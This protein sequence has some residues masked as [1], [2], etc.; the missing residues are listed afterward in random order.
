MENYKIIVGIDIGKEINLISFLHISKKEEITKRLKI[1]NNIEG[2][3]TLLEAL[4]KITKENNCK[5]E[6]VL[7]GLESTGSYWINLY[8]FF[9]R[10]NYKVVMVKNRL[11]KLKREAK[12]SQKGKNDSIDCY[13]I[14]LVLKEGDYFEIREKQV[15]FGSLQRMT[16]TKEDY[17]KV[18][19]Q[20][21]NRLRS[22]LDVNNPIYFRV[23]KSLDSILG[24]A[25]IK[26]FPSPWD[27]ININ[28]NS[29][30][31]ILKED[32]RRV[33]LRC[34]D[35]YIDLCYDLYK[36]VR[37]INEGERKEIKCYL[38]QYDI[39]EKAIN[40]LEESIECLAKET[41]PAYEK[42]I[43]I[44]GIG[45]TEIISLI[46]EIGFIENFPNA[47]ALQSFLG[48]GI[49]ADMSGSMSKESKITKAGN[50]TGRKILYHISMLLITHNDDWR[51]VYSYYKSYNRKYQNI[52]K[53]MLI[54]VACKFLRVVYGILKYNIE[55]DREELFRGY[56]F[57]KCNKEKFIKE[58]IGKSKRTISEEEIKELFG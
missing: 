29:L 1:K 44:K 14:A 12:Y 37:N 36:D 50:R 5:V 13:C 9:T 49:K 17:I 43:K 32:V 23:F 33:D 45:K 25:I 26:K 35:E 6:D 47:R 7:I 48:L 41:V 34:L 24:L 20:N 42:L 3:Y 2:F 18:K 40:D 16:R 52:N 19:V 30:I 54:A 4:N 10:R 38:D 11:V 8:H 56:D 15:G 22:W 53:E 58:Y 57:T 21:K 31:E 55:F 39:L 28:R 46:S 27:I 51:K